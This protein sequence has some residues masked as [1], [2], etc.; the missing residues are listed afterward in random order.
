MVGH[1]LGVPVEET[2]IQIASAGMATV[3]LVGIAG[4]TKL[5][6]LRRSVDRRRGRGNAEDDGPNPPDAERHPST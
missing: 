4:R 2:A 3:A 6:R 5:T 1:I